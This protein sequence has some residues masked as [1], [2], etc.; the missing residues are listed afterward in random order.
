MSKTVSLTA[1]VIIGTIVILI[2]YDVWVFIEP[3]PAD[4]ISEVL[5]RAA[6]GNPIIPFALG[7]V[8]GHLF[9]PQRQP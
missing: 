2:A 1:G 8:F 5:L 6:S 3:S 4:T 9:W 7:V